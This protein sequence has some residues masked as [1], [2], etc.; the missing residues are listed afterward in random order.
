MSIN[1]EMVTRIPEPAPTVAEAVKQIEMKWAGRSALEISGELGRRIAA[2]NDI[3]K[4]THA[5]ADEIS[6][7]ELTK[8]ASL[9][10]EARIREYVAPMLTNP[11]PAAVL[12]KYL[13]HRY[14]PEVETGI[15]AILTDTKL[16]QGYQVK[17]SK[18]FLV[19]YECLGNAYYQ[20]YKEN[21]RKR[22]AT[23]DNYLKHAACFIYNTALFKM[24]REG[25]ENWKRYD[26][27]GADL[28]ELRNLMGQEKSLPAKQHAWTNCCTRDKW[29][30][31]LSSF[32]S[33]FFPEN[34][35]L[36]SI[37]AVDRQW[38]R[39]IAVYANDNKV[40]PGY[41][42]AKPSTVLNAVF[43]MIEHAMSNVDYDVTGGKAHFATTY[44]VKEEKPASQQ[45]AAA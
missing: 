28:E 39:D 34:F 20:M 40:N 9:L 22:L 31:M 43:T 6:I 4:H 21:D 19:R 38:I 36:P 45:E 5:P 15:D 8:L 10:K 42:Y 18:K 23:R 13:D 3:V 1:N 12:Q 14:I 33:D 2:V 24:K 7:A 32:L 17:T 16:L 37:R 44:T 11:D 27:A 25:H 29:D 26:L 30:R 41:S 35:Q